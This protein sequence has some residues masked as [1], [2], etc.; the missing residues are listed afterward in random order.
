MRSR[1]MEE[2]KNQRKKCR[3]NK[4]AGDEWV[5]SQLSSWLKVFMIDDIF[6]HFF[7]LF[8]LPECSQQLL[9]ERKLRTVVIS[10]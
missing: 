1:W 2:G 7:P 4:I 9:Q 10:V 3:R 6:V 5:I 8:A